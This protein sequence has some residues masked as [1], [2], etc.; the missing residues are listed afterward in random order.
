MSAHRITSVTALLLALTACGKDPVESRIEANPE[1]GKIALTQYA[2]HA[3][4]M[5]PGVT[6]SKVFVGPRLEGI[7]SRPMIAGHVPNN[8]D[9]LVAWIRNPKSIDPQTAMPDMGVTEEHARDM[10]AYLSTLK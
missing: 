10:A 4:H 8:T 1:R 3:C 2:C 5:I 7:A 9:N 6:G